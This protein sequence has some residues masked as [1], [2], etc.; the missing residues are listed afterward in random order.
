MPRTLQALIID[1]SPNDAELILRE[2]KRHGYAPQA[3]RID[4]PAALHQALDGKTWDIIIADYAMPRFSGLDALLIVQE[5]RPDIPFIL[6][7]GSIGED[8]AVAAMKSGAH[9]YIMKDRMARLGPAVGQA[10]DK[11]EIRRARRRAEETARYLAYFDPLTNL[12]NLIQFQERLEQAF[13]DTRRDDQP[14]TLMMLNINRFREVNEALGHD[15]GDVFLKLAAA[16]LLRQLRGADFAARFGADNFMLLTYPCGREDA[17]VRGRAIHKAFEQPLTVAGFPLEMGVRIGIA[18]APEHGDNS[19]QLL[20][21]ADVAL[22]LSR[23][24]GVPLSVYDPLRDPSSPKRL[25]LTGELRMAIANRQLVLHYQPKV[26][27]HDG[28]VSGV[29]ALARWEHPE[30]GRV[31]PDEFIPLA[32]KSG[33]INL[34][35]Q[36][37]LDTAMQEAWRWHALDWR[38]PVAVNLSARNMLDPEIV[39]K[40]KSLLEGRAMEAEMLEIEITESALMEDPVRALDI[41]TALNDMGIK[42]YIDDFGT[43]YSSLAYLK[44]LPVTAVK[45]DKSFVLD[46]ASNDDSVTIVRSTIDLAHNLGLKV[47]AE[48]V[49]NAMLLDRLR[50][51]G[52]DEAQGYHIG[53]PVPSAELCEWFTGHT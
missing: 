44:K 45:I 4:T 12:P 48:G 20:Q 46:M 25:R 17:L 11:A 51:F 7:S 49:E 19:R 52:C 36:S 43:G 15:N 27:L 38:V 34:L 40:I 28:T 47:V 2:L 32:E 22:G 30:L 9:D 29:E 6:V 24:D 42:L 10:L 35:T 33:L 53:R 39:H 8:M 41:L 13:D 5:K 3:V 23:H 31:P 26:S 14:F 16:Q 21:R 18:L 1:D 37:V 50:E